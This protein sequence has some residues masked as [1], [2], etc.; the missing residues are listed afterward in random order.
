MSPWFLLVAVLLLA[1]NGYF[2]A[3]EFAVIA[4]RR[5]KLEG[6]AAEGGGAARFAVDATQQ[7]SLQLAGAQLGITM[8]SLGLG[9]V[10]EPTIGALLENVFGVGGVVPEGAQHFLGLVVGLGFVVFA[11]MVFGEMVP[12][13]AT[14]ADPERM[15]VRLAIPN[16]IYLTLFGPIV[17]VLNRLANVCTRLLGVDPRDEVATAHTAVEIASMLAAS[18]QEGLIEATAHDLLSGALDFGERTVAEVMVPRDEVVAVAQRTSVEEAEALVVSS[19]HSRLVV[20]GNDLDDIVGFVHAKDLLTVPSPARHRPLPLARI[21]RVLVL[22]PDRPLDDVL[23]AMKRSRTHVG[24]VRDSGR[25][26]GLL[27]LEDVLEDLVGDIRDETDP[28]ARPRI[29]PRRRVRR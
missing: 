25:T 9:A 1:A 21:R 28:G 10:A 27:T 6:M 12:K 16:R 11:H 3:V 24:V 29:T 17:R 2:V 5:T 13:N 20:S 18:R 19:G 8:A 22:A 15:L 26:L 14:L 23:V 7:L 4:S